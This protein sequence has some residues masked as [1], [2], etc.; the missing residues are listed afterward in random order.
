MKSP[1]AYTYQATVKSAV[2]DE[3]INVYL[4]RPLAGLLVRAVYPTRITPNQLTIAAIGWG[5]IAAALYWGGAPATTAAAG[6]CVTLKDL[7]DSA[8]GQLAR[9]KQLYSRAGRFLD[10]IGDILVNA[11]VFFAF[12]FPL[13]RDTGDPAIPVMAALGFLGI[14][15]RVSYHV[16]YQ[17]SF[18]HL[19]EKYELNRTTEEFRPDDL[20]A[21]PLVRRLQSIFQVLYGWQDRLMVRLDRWCGEGIETGAAWYG[22]ATGL[23]LSGFLGLG[24]EL[25]LLTVCS[26][27]N[28]MRW[29]LFL[30]LVGMNG[31]W[32]MC[33]LYRRV[34]LRAR[35]QTSGG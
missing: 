28:E 20:T 33:V 19:Q 2:S 21:D 5:I 24:S 25:F 32:G 18:L 30:N 4:L 29:Y 13:W 11:L 7:F 14:S 23:R 26:L 3:L 9:A 35:L 15:L 10:S 1:P 17:S 34:V 12:A 27:M 8:D 22:D 16:F 31:I 6:I